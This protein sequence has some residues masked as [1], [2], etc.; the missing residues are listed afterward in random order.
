MARVVD[1]LSVGEL[2]AEHRGSKD[3]TRARHF[4]VIWLLAQGRA[5]AETARL[6]SFAPRWIEGLLVRCNTFGPSSLGDRRRGDGAK[7][8]VLTPEVLDLLRERMKTPPDDGGVWTAR[9]VAVVMATALKVGSLAEQR[10]W[11]ARAARSAGRSS[12]RGRGRGRAA[13]PDEQSAFKKSS[14]RSSPRRR[15][16]T[17]AR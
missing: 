1:H 15:S 12:G 4:R 11:K 17:P 16:A 5:V 2:Q 3:A 6:T 7:A 10:G 8:T 9:K 13:A 14:P